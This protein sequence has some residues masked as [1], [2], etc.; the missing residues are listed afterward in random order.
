ME[1]SLDKRIQEV[2]AF[3]AGGSKVHRT[4]ARVEHALQEL[5][6]DFALVGGLAVYAHGHQRLTGDVNILVTSQGLERFRTHL[7]GR[8]YAE[9]FP[10]SRGVRDAETG[11]P[12]DFLIAGDYPGDGKPKAIRFPDPSAIQKPEAGMRVV[13][14]RT[15]LELKLASG[16]TAPDRLQDLADVITLIRANELT[17]DFGAQLDASVG[18]KYTE[19]WQVAQTPRD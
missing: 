3:F 9:K 14:L 8:G 6:V 11:V 18:D 4:L 13:D 16:M 15:L 10:G 1:E 17:P 7:L 12:I 5:G 2:D 19:L